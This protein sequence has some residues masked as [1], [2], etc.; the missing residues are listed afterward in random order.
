MSEE[1]EYTCMPFEEQDTCMS[2][3][4]ADACMSYGEEN[5]GHDLS[6]THVFVVQLAQFTTRRRIHACHITLRGPT[7]SLYNWRSSRISG[8][9]PSYPRFLPCQ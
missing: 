4:E 7:F 3:E 8:C 2:Y 6:R 9:E 5:A 1:E